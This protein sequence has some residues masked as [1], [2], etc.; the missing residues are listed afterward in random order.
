MGSVKIKTYVVKNTARF[1]SELRLAFLTDVHGHVN[2]SLFREITEQKP[3]VILIGGDMIVRESPETYGKVQRFIMALARR[4]PVIYGPGNHEG[5]EYYG[6]NPAYQAYEEALKKAGV[7]F[8][9]NEKIHLEL[10]GRKVCV[11]G[12]ELPLTYYKRP[13]VPS[14]SL[15]EMRA[16]V[17]EPQPDAYN[18]LLAHNP[19]Y[20]DVY[21][22]WG[23]DLILSGHIHG[24]MVRFTEHAGLISPQIRI[25]PKYCCGRFDREQR[26]MLVSAGLG[27]HSLPIRIHNPRELLIIETR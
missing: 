19:K 6:E 12:L 10:K 21:F 8:L 7:I 15:E 14:L 9:H 5:T 3:D 20:G 23:A 1:S 11:H 2:R 13:L 17:G 26:T 18:I 16:M 27:E 4:Y 25:F 24:G 22:E